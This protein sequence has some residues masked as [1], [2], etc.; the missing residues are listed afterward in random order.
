MQVP[1]DELPPHATLEAGRLCFHPPEDCHTKQRGLGSSAH[2]SPLQDTAPRPQK[3]GGIKSSAASEYLHCEFLGLPQLGLSDNAWYR[4]CRF[5]RDEEE[6]GAAGAA[7]RMR[8][9][10]RWVKRFD[11]LPDGVQRRLKRRLL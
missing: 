10:F 9:C 6:Q 3:C 2:R 1:D 11:N 4:E 7:H 5:P 8:R